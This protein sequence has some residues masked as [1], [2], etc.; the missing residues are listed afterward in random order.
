MLLHGDGSAQS[1]PTTG[2]GAGAS[3]VVTPF[4]ADASTNNFNVTING[5][6]R[7]N[8]FTPYQAGYYSNYFDGTSGQYLNAPANTVFNFGTGDFTVEAW[9]LPTSTSGTRPIIE[10]RTTGGANGFALLSQSGATTLNVYTNGGFVGVSTNTLTLNTWNHVALT[11]STNTW[12]YWINGVSGG[13]FTN[14]STQSDGGTTGPKI[15][16][17]TTAGEIWIGY[18]SNARITKGAALYTTTFTPSTTPLTTTVSSGT[19]SLLTSQSNR[20]IDNSTN[21]FTITVNGSPQVAPAQPFTLPTSV[22]TYGSGYFDGSGDYLSVASQTALGMGSGDFTYEAWIYVNEIVPT[23][24]L[25]GLYDSRVAGAT[26]CGIYTSADVGTTSKLVYTTNSAI[27][28]SSTNTIKPYCWTH[29]AVARSSGTVRGFL[30]GVLEFTVTDSRTFSSSAAT[31]IATDISPQYFNGYINDARILKGTALYTSAF[32]PPTAPL[33]AI[34]NT[35]LLTTQYNGA[36]NNNGFKDSSQN[37]FVITRNGN[38]T[39]G[40]FTPYEANWSNYFNGSSGVTVSSTSSQFGFSGD[41]TWEAWVN[42]NSLPSSGGN[43][44]IICSRG[45]AAS[46][47]AFQFLIGNSSG[48]YQIT[49]TISISSSDSNLIWNI[50]SA[51]SVGTWYH[52]AI[53]RS[54]SSVQA[55][56]NG[57]AIGSAQTASGTTNTPT[58]NPSIGFRG[59]AYNDLFFNGYISNLRMVG[60]ALYTAA[61]TPSVTPLTAISGTRILTCA[62]NR[63]IDDST[64]AFTLTAY[65]SPSVQSFSPFAPLVV[66]NPAVNGGSAYFDGT[67]DWLTTP[68]GQ[69][70]LTLGTSDFTIEMWVYPTTQVRGN[71][72]LF[73]SDPGIGLANAI[74]SQFNGTTGQLTLWVNNVNLT[75]SSTTNYIRLNQWNH[76]AICRSGGSTYSF[77]INGTAVNNVATNST[78]LTTNSWYVGYWTVADNAYTGYISD[79]RIIKGTVLYTSNFTPNTAPLT[80]VANTQLLLNFTNA[81]ILDNAMMNDL[82][83]VGNAQIST[84]VK[85]YGTGSLYFDGTDDRLNMPAS[86][87]LAFGTGD[88]TLEMWAYFTSTANFPTLTDSRVNTSST[89]GFNLGLSSAKVQLYTTSQ[90]LIGSS[91]LSANTW[92][93]IAVTRASGTLKIWLNGVQDATVSN[94]TNWSDQTFVVGATPSAANL[95]TGYIDDLRLTKGYARY[96]A[97][98]TPPTA[99]F[100]NG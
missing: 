66:Y 86:P 65:S 92:Y 69:T 12:T 82:E 39:Q 17:S 1:L 87:N 23:N 35:S 32:T 73:T 4:N 62:D 46:N 56:W 43:Y 47:S 5:D 38:T 14:S 29:V 15:G 36:G 19:V 24:A 88:F 64:N 22:A 59:G 84:S 11:R 42:L 83:T 28:A 100:P 30:N 50:P 57:A 25:R 33:T 58:V 97:T 8:N 13:S 63:F 81:G 76:V 16:G 67:S 95:M 98:F 31:Y 78:S 55:Y 40:T 48:T 71:P 2:V 99:A 54:G 44:S 27:A 70:A 80:A 7:S 61:F 72:S 77:Y 89:A 26:G 20:F 93:H 91:T 79:T 85:K 68:T 18:I 96:T 51:P 9:V 60:S 21:A 10:I 94:S 41:F 6:A 45:A 37:N 75:A 53:V 49:G 90:L 74:M 34:T 52:V 3:A